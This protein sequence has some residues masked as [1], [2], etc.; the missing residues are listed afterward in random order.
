[1]DHSKYYQR[2]E[3]A[4]VEWDVVGAHPKLMTIES[5]MPGKYNRNKTQG[6]DH[7]FPISPAWAPLK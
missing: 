6:P 4:E 2:G 7:G 5:F 1:M 3:A